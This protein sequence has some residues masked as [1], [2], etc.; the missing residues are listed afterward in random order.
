[1]GGRR[2]RRLLQLQELTVGRISRKGNR[3]VTGSE[4]RKLHRTKYIF[5]KI[6]PFTT[7]TPYLVKIPHKQI[8]L[9]TKG[10]FLHIPLMAH[11][12]YFQI[13]RE[14]H[15]TC[16]G[17]PDTLYCVH[18]YTAVQLYWNPVFTALS[19][20]FFC[21]GTST[22]PGRVGAGCGRPRWVWCTWVFPQKWTR[23]AMCTT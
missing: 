18:S 6:I 1:M 5:Y 23:P 14:K 21:Y 19:L 17:E 16:G 12:I 8:N 4:S 7:I 20:S 10:L 13:G 2:L 15:C 22:G 9:R 11:I 3:K